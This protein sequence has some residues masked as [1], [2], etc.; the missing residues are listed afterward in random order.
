MVASKLYRKVHYK[1]QPIFRVLTIGAA[2]QQII[3]V[4]HDDFII[5]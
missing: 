2:M 4:D 3:L 5:K 1:E